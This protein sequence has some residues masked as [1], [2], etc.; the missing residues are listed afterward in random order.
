M[1]Y[2]AKNVKTGVRETMIYSRTRDIID[3]DNND[4]NRPLTTAE[5]E[6]AWARFATV[7]NRHK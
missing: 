1:T 5:V 3:A 2:Y 6:S 4:K 7:V